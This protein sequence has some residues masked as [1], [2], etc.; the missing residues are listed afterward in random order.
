[1]T[2]AQ[3]SKVSRAF[4]T[5]I[6]VH[7]DVFLSQHALVARFTD[8]SQPQP[9]LFDWGCAVDMS[10]AVHRRAARR[11]ERVRKVDVDS[12]AADSLKQLKQVGARRKAQL[13]AERAVLCPQSW[14]FFLWRSIPHHVGL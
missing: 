3:H 12:A 13:S 10:K 6:P 7:G 1:M 9:T 2:V 11:K 14:T 8:L 5:R 4:A